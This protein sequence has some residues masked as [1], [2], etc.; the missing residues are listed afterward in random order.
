MKQVGWALEWA[1]E[2]LR[3]DDEVTIEADKPDGGALELSHE[4]LME[5][6]REV[7]F[8]AA[9]KNGQALEWASENLKADKEV[10]LK[11]VK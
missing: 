6:Y 10:D 7:V 8:E 11:A 3:A 1:P 2:E 5:A 9:K 4:E